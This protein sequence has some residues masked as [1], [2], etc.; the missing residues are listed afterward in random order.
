MSDAKL[1]D[2]GHENTLTQGDILAATAITQFYNFA[3]RR[4]RIAGPVFAGQAARGSLR[5]FTV[6]AGDCLPT[7]AARQRR[8]VPVEG[9]VQSSTFMHLARPTPR[10]TPIV[11]QWVSLRLSHRFSASLQIRFASESRHLLQRPPCPL[12]ATLRHMRCSKC[13]QRKRNPCGTSRFIIVAA[14]R[15]CRA[16]MPRIREFYWLVFAAYTAIVTAAQETRSDIS[17]GVIR[18]SFGPAEFTKL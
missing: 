1:N 8:L 3:S 11:F 9:P 18:S 10:G 12:S 2:V 14:A 17:M 15:R 6:C 4:D 7:A 5:C 16:P 13:R